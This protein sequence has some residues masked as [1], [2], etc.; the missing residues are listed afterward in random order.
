MRVK[1]L[2]AL[3]LLL[4]AN[5]FLLVHAVL[6]HSHH[7]GVVCFSLSELLHQNHCSDAHDDIG[8]CCCEHEEHS[9]H[10]HA[11]SEDCD[12]KEIVLRHDNTTHEDIL[13]C[14]D[15]LSLL[16][17]I[18]SLN[19]LYLLAPQFGQ[20]LEIKPY[21]ITYISPYV[22]TIKSLRAPPVAYF[23]G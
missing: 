10:H 23:L 12:L 6:P 4:L 11:N 7:D 2:A 3:T 20:R 17:S 9:Q 1:R 14:P 18:Y 13:P 22:G 21:L 5:M 15:C 8:N 19:D 16:Y